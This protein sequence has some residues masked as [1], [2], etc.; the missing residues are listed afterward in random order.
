[1][2][3]PAARIGGVRAAAYRVPTEQPESDGTL[4]WDA[5]TLVV[6]EVHAGGQTG[7]GYTY[8][9]AAAAGLIAGTLAEAIRGRD[10][11]GHRRRV[12]GD[13]RGRSATSAGP[14]SAPRAISAV[15]VALWD[16]KARLLGLCLAD[17][18]GRDPTKRCR[19]TARAG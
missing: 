3:P 9:D 11:H 6:A 4:E 5:V 12:V 19:S 14:G 15:D 18:L 2:S 7:L 8:T 17:L 1:M 13:G 16:L 10:A